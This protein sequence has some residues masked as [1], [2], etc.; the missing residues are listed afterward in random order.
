MAL[1]LSPLY[2]LYITW[3]FPARIPVAKLKMKYAAIAVMNCKGCVN[4]KQALTAATSTCKA[5]NSTMTIHDPIVSSNTVTGAVDSI[6][7]T[8]T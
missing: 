3:T 8:V 6:Y 4:R 2:G 1:V 7:A 5:L